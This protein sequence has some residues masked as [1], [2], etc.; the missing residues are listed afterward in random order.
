MASDKRMVKDCR[1]NIMGLCLYIRSNG[2][3]RLKRIRKVT[4]AAGWRVELRRTR[5]EF[6]YWS[7]VD[8]ESLG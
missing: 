8:Y 5:P 3:G 7:T 4:L 6:R 1:N 2:R